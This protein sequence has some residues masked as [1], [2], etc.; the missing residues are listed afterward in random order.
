MRLSLE[1]IF[2]VDRRIVFI[3]VFLALLL[4][5]LFP[6]AMPC[7]ATRDVRDMFN[8]IEAATAAGKPVFLSFEW[9]PTGA[10][11]HEPMARSIVRHIFARGGK[12]VVICK[13]NG[14]LGEALHQQVL[15]DCAQEYDKSYG[16]DYVYLPF[17]PGSSILVINLG[18]S[19]L[20]AWPKDSRGDDLDKIGA[21][22]FSGGLFFVAAKV[23]WLMPNT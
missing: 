11:E 22:G 16:E 13:S 1:S 15:E 17:K 19:L 3:F 4:P 18:Q 7:K 20:S 6:Y 21:S 23:P 12:T 5:L 2:N 10:A 9:E 8:A 14:Q